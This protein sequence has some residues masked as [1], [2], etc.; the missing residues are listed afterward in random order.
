MGWVS[1]KVYAILNQS[2]EGKDII[3]RLPDM[4]QEETEKEVDAFFSDGGKGASF[5][6]DYADAKGEQQTLDN[7]ERFEALKEQWLNNEMTDKEMTEIIGEMD[8][9]DDALKKE[10]EDWKKGLSDDEDFDEDETKKE[11]F[12]AKTDTTP[13]DTPLEKSYK[14][15]FDASAK[16]DKEYQKTE[17]VANKEFRELLSTTEDLGHSRYVLND[18]ELSKELTDAINSGNIEDYDDIIEEIDN[19]LDNNITEKDYSVYRV[20]PKDSKN[21]DNKSYLHASLHPYRVK[22]EAR[23]NMKDYDLQVIKVPKGSKMITSGNYHELEVILPRETN[24]KS[25]KN[26]NGIQ[27]YTIGE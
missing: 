11:D 8:V 7:R 19:A 16:I 1:K 22:M 6:S 20:V 10:I 13:E 21:E 3:E 18:T 26:D 27:Y 15:I 23:E 17:S 2:E 4:S 14:N 24:L 5:G 9:K 25:I 12:D